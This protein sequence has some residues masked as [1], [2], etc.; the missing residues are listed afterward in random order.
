MLLVRHHSSLIADKAHRSSTL[1]DVK[2]HPFYAGIAWDSLRDTP[3]PF[4]PAL[5]SEVDAG[6]F[7][8]F[9]N[10]GKPS[11]ATIEFYLLQS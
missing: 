1:D 5:D 2:R 3:A 4:V 9:S 11:S 10:P 7:D 8:D 6:Y